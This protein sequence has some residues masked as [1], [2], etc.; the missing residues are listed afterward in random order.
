MIRLL[1]DYADKNGL[2]YYNIADPRATETTLEQA[3]GYFQNC[4]SEDGGKAFSDNM[5]KAITTFTNALAS[6]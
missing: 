1:Q 2:E 5:D 6:E 3:K 4:L